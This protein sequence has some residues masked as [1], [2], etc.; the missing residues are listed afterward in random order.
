MPGQFFFFG[1]CES[2][3]KIVLGAFFFIG[4]RKCSVSSAACETLSS[5]S[6]K[7][8]LLCMLQRVVSVRL[9]SAGEIK[10]SEQK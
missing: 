2:Y 5:K 8:L 10:I 6:S 9:I 7:T 3:G 1:K 4:Q